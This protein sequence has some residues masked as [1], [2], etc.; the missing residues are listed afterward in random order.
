MSPAGDI[1]I[2]S[3]IC[4]ILSHMEKDTLVIDFET[5]KS[6][7]EV[8]G[9]QNIRELGISVA[10]VYSYA[11][12]AFFA[13]E[14]QELPKFEEMLK[15]TG[16]LIGFNLVHFDIP[17]IEPYLKEVKIDRIAVTDIFVDAVNF[18]GHRVGLGGVAKATLGVSKSGHG[19][20]ALEWFKQGRVDDV[21]KYCL[22][23]VRITR[24]LYEYGKKHN[25]ILFESFIDG[26]IHSIPVSWGKE[27]VRPVLQ[28]L[29]EGLKRRR[30]ISIEYVSSEDSDGLG[31]RKSRL[32][33]IYKIRPNGEI[34]AYCHLRKSL[35][36][37]RT[38]RIL[39]AELTSDS[40]AIPSDFQNVLF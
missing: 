26:K 4:F 37:F 6:F 24:D 39:K 7:A 19:L 30:R 2:F 21:K 13:F 11:K 31:F 23:D 12:G 8:G 34:E 18:L 36:N 32:I 33:D 17:V 1:L 25:H 9:E 27:I 3:R 20:E 29:E 35:R 10:G 28:I 40:Y 14:E 16:H 15:N 38:N 5:K 22:D